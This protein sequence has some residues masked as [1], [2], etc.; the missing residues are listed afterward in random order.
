MADDL[1]YLSF[2]HELLDQ[3]VDLLLLVVLDL[4]LLIGEKTQPN[5]T[6]IPHQ[7]ALRVQVVFEL[8]RVVDL[9]PLLRLLL[10][11]IANRMPQSPLLPALHHVGGSYLAG[12]HQ[13]ETQMHKSL[14][15]CL[16]CFL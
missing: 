6:N 3:R 4:D 14:H 8:L 12:H 7:L 11:P 15:N 9:L 1:A 5:L 2:G 13:V 16:Y 10:V